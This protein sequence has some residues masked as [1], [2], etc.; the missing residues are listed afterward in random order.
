MLNHILAEYEKK[1]KSFLYKFFS[2]FA[3]KISKMCK[4][5]VNYSRKLILC[6]SQDK[7]M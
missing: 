1:S 5:A 3:E 4:D 7:Y 2:F 6:F